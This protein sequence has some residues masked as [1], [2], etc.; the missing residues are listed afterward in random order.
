MCGRYVSTNAVSK[1][2]HLVD[3]PDRVLDT[4]NFNAYPT[5]FLPVLL[6]RD[7]KLIIQ[8]FIK[9]RK[10]RQIHDFH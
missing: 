7:K 4:E 5:C 6:H 9:F 2:K 3:N 8:N 10:I 1:T